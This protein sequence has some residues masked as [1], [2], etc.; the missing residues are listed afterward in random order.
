[1]E[2]QAD[3]EAANLTGEELYR[4][5][6]AKHLKWDK[7]IETALRTAGKSERWLNRLFQD[8]WETNCD[9]RDAPIQNKDEI[10]ELLANWN[11]IE[12]ISGLIGVC[13]LSEERF[14]VRAGELYPSELAAAVNWR[15]L[16]R[17]VLTDLRGKLDEK[18]KQITGTE[19][20]E[21]SSEG[22]VERMGHLKA[23]IIERV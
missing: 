21:R 4:W 14:V 3:P 9:Y 16:E 7:K 8:W 2:L 11:L 1:M 19:A 22:T 17:R 15:R 5:S 12:E 13:G 20:G 6:E 23:A 10:L 18:Q